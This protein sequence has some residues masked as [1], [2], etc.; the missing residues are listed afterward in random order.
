MIFAVRHPG[1]LSSQGGQSSDLVVDVG[2]VC[3]RDLVSAL[4]GPCRVTGQGQKLT[5]RID[6]ESKFARMTDEA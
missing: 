3:L 6:V 5:D 4:A 2:K 1:D